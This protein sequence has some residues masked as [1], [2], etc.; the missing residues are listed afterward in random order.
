MGK[1]DKG[2]LPDFVPLFL[3]TLDSPAWR[4]TSH[5]A[6]CLY[7][8]LKRQAFGT[9]KAYLSYRDAEKKVKASRR[10]IQVAGKVFM[11]YIV[12]VFMMDGKR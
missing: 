4:A 7:V 5:G 2:R 1:R 10:K 9:Y 3:G 11:A 12:P 8:A 6:Q